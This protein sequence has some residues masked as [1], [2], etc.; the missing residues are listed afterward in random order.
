MYTRPLFRQKFRVRE[1][2]PGPACDARSG[3]RPIRRGTGGA[4]SRARTGTRPR[5]SAVCDRGRRPEGRRPGWV[6]GRVSPQFSRP[7]TSAAD[8][9]SRH[10]LAMPKT[11]IRGISELPGGGSLTAD[12][13]TGKPFRPILVEQGGHMYTRGAPGFAT[14]LP[15]FVRARGREWFADPARPTTHTRRL[16]TKKG[17]TQSQ[18]G[19]DIP[20]VMSGQA[21]G[22]SR[23]A[24]LAHFA[25]CSRRAKR[26]HTC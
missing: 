9:L 22:P 17:E 18:Q 24:H 14:P 19:V 6:P 10:D 13:Y 23:A 26:P 11:A 1:A 3:P 7:S 8:A 12:V 4:W 21:P 25:S 16:R 20:C 2:S 5:G 15:P